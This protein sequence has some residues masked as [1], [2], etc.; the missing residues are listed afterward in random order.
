MARSSA[1]GD[2]K[3]VHK[4][5]VIF[6]QPPMENEE[7]KFLEIL[8]PMA[9]ENSARTASKGGVAANSWASMPTH[10]F[11]ALV[12]HAQNLQRALINTFGIPVGAPDF[13]WF[14]VPTKKGF[15]DIPFFAAAPFL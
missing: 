13:D 12:S 3:V 5:E 1:C 11:E 9:F 6:V 2:C 15:V 10:P 14:K 8:R 4:E 7:Y